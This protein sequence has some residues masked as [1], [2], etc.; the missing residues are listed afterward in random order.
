MQCSALALLAAAAYYSEEGHAAL[1]LA[2]AEVKKTRRFSSRFFFLVDECR[3]FIEADEG[4]RPGG[5]SRENS[6]E[7]G[8]GSRALLSRLST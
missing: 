6:V 8:A 2:L 1:L 5:L 3:A 4:E 7:F